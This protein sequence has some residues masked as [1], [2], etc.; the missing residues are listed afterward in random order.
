M[1][2]TKKHRI[3]Q[4]AFIQ[5]FL[6]KYYEFQDDYMDWFVAEQLAMVMS[7]IEQSEDLE[8]FEE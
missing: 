5:H 3:N 4:R 7:A 1:G 8:F 6:R 2:K